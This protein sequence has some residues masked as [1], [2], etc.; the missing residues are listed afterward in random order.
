MAVPTQNRESHPAGRPMRNATVALRGGNGRDVVSRVVDGDANFI[1]VSPAPRL[2]SDSSID[3]VWGSGMAYQRATARV[4]DTTPAGL[5]LAIGEAQPIERRYFQRAAPPRPLIAEVRCLDRAG[6][7][8]TLLNCPVNDL[9][10]GGVGFLIDTK[11]D[12]GSAVEITLRERDGRVILQRVRGEV[13]RVT[14]DPRGQIAGAR[15]DTVWE[16]VHALHDLLG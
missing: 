13:V 12:E 10:V 4:I 1:C 6:K 8:T 11:L 9:S 14:V 16:C 15:F 7:V 3:I 2:P 5:W